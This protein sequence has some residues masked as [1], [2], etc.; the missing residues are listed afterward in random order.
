MNIGAGTAVFEMQNA[1]MSDFI[2]FDNAINGGGPKP[3]PGVVSF[4]VTWEA[5]VPAVVNDVPAKR[6]HGEHAPALAQMEW[7]GRAGDFEFVSQPIGTSSSPS[8]ALLG[9]QRTGSFY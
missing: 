9:T 3:R 7:S 4:K 1:H 6:F 5:N 8:G 2:S